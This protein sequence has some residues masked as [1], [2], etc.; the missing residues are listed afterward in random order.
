MA[1]IVDKNKCT[2]C[3]VCIDFCPEHAIIK[4]DGKAYVTIDCVECGGCIEE[5][6]P[7]AISIEEE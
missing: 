6:G 7:E 5:C 4:K 1:V 2:G 3:D